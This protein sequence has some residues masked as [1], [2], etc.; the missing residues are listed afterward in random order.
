MSHTYIHI[1]VSEREGAAGGEEGGALRHRRKL[2][3]R[4]GEVPVQV[5][6]WVGGL[7]GGW[8]GGRVGGW[9]GG[10][11]GGYNIYNI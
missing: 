9:V 6:G 4:M 2:A 11:V 10:W 7:V 5:G 3:K 8:V 1:Q